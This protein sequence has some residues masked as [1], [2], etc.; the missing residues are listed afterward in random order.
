M[1]LPVALSAAAL[2]LGATGC[3]ERTEPLGPGS[4]QYPVAVRDAAGTLVSL[5]THPARIVAISP[6]A[7][8]VL[9]DLG[10]GGQL[11]GPARGPNALWRLAGRKLLDAV[12]AL[13]PDLVVTTSE[14]ERIDRTRIV[15]EL[16]VPLYVLPDA[17]F[18]DVDVAL[19]GLGL[20]TD[21]GVGS[22]QLLRANKRA[23]A[24]VAR[25]LRG[26]PVVRVFVDTGFFQTVSSRSFVSD[27]FRLARGRNVIGPT[28]E[29]GPVD[30]ADLVR[31][32]P[33]VYLATRDSGTTLADLRRNK[34][35]RRISAIRAG[36]F[37]VVN[38]RLLGPAGR[39]A[40]R[41][42]EVARLLHPDASG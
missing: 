25:R 15:R 6:P 17:R 40:E 10:A 19:I 30:I 3:G 18:R 23:R 14:T 39:L 35:T 9:R 31:L 16:K 7:I 27:L 24:A 4:A 28:P 12:R 8:A 41:L 26:E 33:Q 29:P 2:L 36:A 1:R 42:E 20:L 22:R 32:D 38:N 5:R 37:R 13:E 34:R 21:H 11:V